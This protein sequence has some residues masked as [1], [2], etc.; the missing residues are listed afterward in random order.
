VMGIGH[1][2]AATL[3]TFAAFQEKAE[4]AEET[5]SIP[6]LYS[7]PSWSS[8]GNLDPELVFQACEVAC[9]SEKVPQIEGL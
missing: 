7:G 1:L 6:A 3:V 5:A 4:S 2:E 8:R 9:T